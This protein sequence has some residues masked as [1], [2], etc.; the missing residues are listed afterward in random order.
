MER[1]G[2][3]GWEFAVT[4]RDEFRDAPTTSRFRTNPAGDGLWVYRD[5]GAWYADGSPVM[6]FQQIVGTCE[7]HLPAE[8][9]R[10]YDRVRYEWTVKQP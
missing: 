10:A 1:Y 6:E 9:K 4:T 8:R 5:S 7:F 3:H 2:T